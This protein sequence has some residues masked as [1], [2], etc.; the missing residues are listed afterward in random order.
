[1]LLKFMSVLMDQP[2][3]A[4]APAAFL[5][6]TY[7][8]SK[9][10]FALVAATLWFL[11]CFYELAMKHRVLCSGECNIRIDL[12]VLYPTLLIA[13]LAGLVAA[14]AALFKRGKA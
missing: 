11:Y 4:L 13:S 3:L 2:F 12:L 1:M 5:Y 7:A 10:R 6:A 14:G 9:S 8:A